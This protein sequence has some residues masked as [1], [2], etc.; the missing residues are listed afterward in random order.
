MS[1]ESLFDAWERYKAL[2]RSCPF[3]DYSDYTQI[4]M[5]IKETTDEYRRMISALA[6]GYYVN[7]RG[8]DC[9]RTSLKDVPKGDTED[10]SPK[11]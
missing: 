10:E 8:R 6:E 7:G 2:L 4:S 3:H 9:N 5:F 1:F 11:Q